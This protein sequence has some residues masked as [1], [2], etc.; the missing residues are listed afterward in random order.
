MDSVAVKDKQ[1]AFPK[2]IKPMPSALSNLEAI[3]AICESSPWL[4]RRMARAIGSEIRPILELGAGFGSIT[5][6]LPK[7]AVSLER[8]IIRYTYLRELFPDRRILED[9]ALAYLGNLT[10]PTVVVSCIPSVNNSEFKNIR[11]CVSKAYKAGLI[12]KLITYTYFPHNP[13]VDI[14]KK[15]EILGLELINFPPA[16]VWRYS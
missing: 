8:E 6:V 5:S 1:A 13:F 11:S 2:L 9:C 10:I 16:F 12:P 15:S 7:D 3:G 4:A 14:F